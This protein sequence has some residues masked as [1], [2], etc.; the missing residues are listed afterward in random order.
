MSRRLRIGWTCSDTAHHMHHWYWSAWLCGQAQRLFWF[1]RV[2][3]A[4]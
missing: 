3:L 4:R 1:I 2:M